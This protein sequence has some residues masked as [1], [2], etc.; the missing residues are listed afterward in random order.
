M[1]LLFGYQDSSMIQETGEYNTW[2]SPRLWE[3]V[4]IVCTCATYE[5]WYF[6]IQE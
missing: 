6:I 5:V 2:S 1:D 3:V 4:T